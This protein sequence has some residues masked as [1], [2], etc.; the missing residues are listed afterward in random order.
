M[1]SS[2]NVGTA[3]QLL[4][5]GQVVAGSLLLL[6]AMAV[7]ATSGLVVFLQTIAASVTTFY[8]VFV[9]LKVFLWCGSETAR[10]PRYRIPQPNDLDLPRYTILVPLYREANV[11]EPLVKALSSLHYPASKIEVLLLLEPDDRETL[12]ALERAALPGNFRVLVVSTAGPRTK[13]KACNYGYEHATGD[14][15][16]IFDAEDRPDPD[17]LLR[18]V[19]AFRT[20]TDHDP[21]VAC[22]Q[23]KLAFWN[24]RGRWISSFYWAEY[25]VHFQIV[26]AGLWRLGLIPPLGGT[27]NHFRMDALD[28]V[29]RANGAWRFED[30][31][32][33]GSIWG[34]WDPYNVT[35]DA[36]LAFR[37]A[38]AGFRIGMLDSK[39]YEEAPD[40][41][42]KA[43]NQRSRWLQGYMQTGLVHTRYPLRS[44]R[45]VG[46]LRYLAFILFILGTPVSLMLNP[47]VWGVTILYIASRLAGDPAA[48]VFINTLFPAPVYYAGMLVAVVGNLALYFQ[49]LTTPLRRQQE[50]HISSQAPE[51]HPLAGY[52]SLQ[53]YGLTAR[54][55]LTPLWWAFTSISAYR[56][57]RKLLIPSQRSH[58]DKTPHGHAMAT[59][60]EL[61]RSSTMSSR[62]S[63]WGTTTPA[64]RTFAAHRAPMPPRTASR[65]LAAA[66]E[67]RSGWEHLAT[68]GSGTGR[69]VPPRRPSPEP[70]R[71]TMS[72]APP[73]P[74][75][76]AQLAGIEVLRTLAVTEPLRAVGPEMLVLS[77][78][79]GRDHGRPNGLGQPGADVHFHRRSPDLGDSRTFRTTAGPGNGDE[80]LPVSARGHA[81]RRG[82]AGLRLHRRGP[83]RGP[84]TAF[85]L[86]LL[87]DGCFLGSEYLFASRLARPAVSDCLPARN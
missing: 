15:L 18:A 4:S 50:T 52:L 2:R 58:W 1:R 13:P 62:R 32:G 36:D 57:L 28:A 35:E 3:A 78:Q 47:I 48:A 16:V 11:I 68:A 30:T 80:A 21:R 12:A 59:E 26:L 5:R 10:I 31:D 25:V 24:P 17:Q 69:Q 66:T 77:T 74:D 42:G 56:A 20:M 6:T 54:L 33:E 71:R 46:P 86:I 61:E 65:P 7:W 53:E 14:M 85:S 39:T 23:A 79:A 38:L 29:A 84:P 76:L 9:G 34:P 82:C 72:A 43:R 75:P 19:G 41:A 51:Q 40:T 63:A 37:L 87:A 81:G 73:D 55:L 49:N 60:A 64:P 67:G 83:R 27:S 8:L 22:L 45:R 44:M 70:L